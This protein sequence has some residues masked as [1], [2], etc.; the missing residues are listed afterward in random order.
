MELLAQ[1]HPLLPQDPRSSSA[2][3]RQL[4]P[5]LRHN[6]ASVRRAAV[7]LF[8]SLLGG[9]PDTGK[10]CRRKSLLNWKASRTWTFIV[11]ISAKPSGALPAI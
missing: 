5:F 10:W 11:Q 8:K 3:V 4:W 9:K 6:L 2:Y 1:L 7:W